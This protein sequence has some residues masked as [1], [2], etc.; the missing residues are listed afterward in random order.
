MRTIAEF[1]AINAALFA[2]QLIAATVVLI[3]APLINA[4]IPHANEK[5]W[6]WLF[7]MVGATALAL[8]VLRAATR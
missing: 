6:P 2:A 7:L 1:I 4:T 5:V 3:M 8:N